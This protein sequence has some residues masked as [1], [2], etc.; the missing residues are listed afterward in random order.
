MHL[1]EELGYAIDCT[2][3]NE[4][5]EILASEYDF[6]LVCLVDGHL[7]SFVHGLR[8]VVRFTSS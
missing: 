1:V 2:N 4:F 8:R 6:S 3:V 7:Q 5:N